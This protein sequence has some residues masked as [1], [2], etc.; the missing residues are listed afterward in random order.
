MQR[1]EYSS[2]YTLYEDKLMA[3][4]YSSYTTKISDAQKAL[5]AA[6]DKYYKR[7]STMETALAKINSSSGSLSS[8]F[9]G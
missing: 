1:T 6:Q 3:S 9:G 8:F 2:A 5:E 7:F 4:Q